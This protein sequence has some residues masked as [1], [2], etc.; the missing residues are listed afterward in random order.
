MS[1]ILEFLTD[2]MEDGSIKQDDKEGIE[3]ASE[4]HPALPYL[5][6]SFRLIA[7]L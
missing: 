2:S 5:V 1:S 6:P 4:T 7:C 3:V